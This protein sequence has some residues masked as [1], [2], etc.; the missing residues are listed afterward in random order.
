MEKRSGRLKSRKLGIE[1]L[2]V[3]APLIEI[4]EEGKRFELTNLGRLHVFT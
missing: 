1:R 2:P 4:G 3:Q